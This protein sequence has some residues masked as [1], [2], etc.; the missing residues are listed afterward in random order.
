MERVIIKGYDLT[1]LT[2]VADRAG[3][4]I[5]FAAGWVVK[6]IKPNEVILSNKSAPADQPTEIRIAIADVKDIYKGSGI[7]PAYQ[8]ANREGISLVVQATTVAREEL[9]DGSGNLADGSYR[10]DFPYKSWHVIQTP[11]SALITSAVLEDLKKLVDGALFD[12]AGNSNLG[13]MLK[14]AINPIA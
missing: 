11:K 5:D 12:S 9:Q 14:G 8:G 6:T 10:V 7:N 3:Y 2:A 4:K 13:N 1:G